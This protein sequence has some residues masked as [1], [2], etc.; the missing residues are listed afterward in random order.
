MTRILLITYTSNVREML[1]K[2][3][4]FFVAKIYRKI[5]SAN[6]FFYFSLSHFLPL[7]SF[8][9]VKNINLIQKKL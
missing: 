3:L 2:N 8:Y 4:E 9:M 1:R 5:A 7:N 6:V